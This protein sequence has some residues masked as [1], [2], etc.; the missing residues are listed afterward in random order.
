MKADEKI[1]QLCEIIREQL[2]PL[3]NR[4]YWLLEVPYYTN[5]GDTLIWQGELDFLASIP[6]RRKGMC[7]FYS[8]V[9]ENIMEDD[10]ILFQGGGN[11]GDLWP[12]S[13][14]FKIEVVKRYPKN[15]IIFLPQTVWFEDDKNL[16]ESAEFLSHS[17]NITICARDSVSYDIL[18]NNFSNNILLVPDMAFYIDMKRWKKNYTQQGDLLLM[19]GDKELK[20]NSI[21]DELANQKDIVVTDWLPFTE[22]CW[23]KTWFRRTKKY[24]PFMYDWYAMNVFRTYLINSGIE[25]INSHRKIFSTRLH[26]AI[27]CVLLGKAEDLTWFDNSYGKNSNFYE[28]WLKDCD[29]I[30]FIK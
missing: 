14:K 15:R 28:T 17:P 2:T 8:S 18:K 29:G 24:L 5:V 11:F 7:S 12:L 25:L 3:I 27:L 21:L 19:R 13:H 9:P 26:A 4:D 16:K 1:S 20:P 23:Q 22:Y 30:K 6:Y 10:I